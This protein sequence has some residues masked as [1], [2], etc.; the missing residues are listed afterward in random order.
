MAVSGEMSDSSSA[1]DEQVAKLKEEVH[2]LREQIKRSQRLA[3]IGTMAAMVVHEFNN[4]LT[5]II[6]YAHLAQ[7]NPA[8]MEKAI[9]KAA[10]GGERARTICGAILG[11]SRGD[12]GEPI[13]R[14][15]AELVDQALSAMARAP[16]RDGIELRLDIP[17][18]LRIRT[19]PIEMEHVLLNLLINARRAV[20][21]KGAMKRIG[22]SVCAEGDRCVLSVT[23][24]G[25]GIPPENIDQVFEPFF[26]TG[27]GSD[28]EGEGGTG[29]GLTICQEIV[30]AMHGQIDVQSRL[31]E[32]TTF[33]ITLPLAA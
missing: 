9:A 28:T 24:N 10:D 19:R 16:A 20:L 22:I 1:H 29:L 11:I 21:Q 33:T 13:D 6:N 8:L 30:R 12:S 23:D 3:S 7:D 4:I 18:D 26:S 31:G 14:N 25:V 27:K 5:P 15:V 2:A 32:G 17:G